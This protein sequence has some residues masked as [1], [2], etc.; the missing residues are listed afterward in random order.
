MPSNI[1]EQLNFSKFYSDSDIDLDIKKSIMTQSQMMFRPGRNSIQPIMIYDEISMTK[2]LEKLNAIALGMDTNVDKHLPTM[3]QVIDYF[4]EY[5][6]HE[7]AMCN[8][9]FDVKEGIIVTE[10]IQVAWLHDVDWTLT[11]QTNNFQQ[12]Y[13]TF[14]LNG[15]GDYVSA[16]FNIMDLIDNSEK[17]IPD[18]SKLKYY[19]LIKRLDYWSF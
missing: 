18:P 13:F 19:Q 3:E 4:L 12:N 7:F 8:P 17:E 6:D 5:D 11:I 1:I 15:Y 9:Q 16:H 14:N 2:Q 10:G